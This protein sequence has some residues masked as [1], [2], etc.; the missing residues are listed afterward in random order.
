MTII[1]SAISIRISRFL[2]NFCLRAFSSAA[3]FLDLPD[4]EDDFRAAVFFPVPADVLRLPVPPVLF[5]FFE[6]VVDEDPLFLPEA[7]FPVLCAILFLC[8]LPF[9]S[10][11]F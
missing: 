8:V 7:P 2:C 10:S 6:D 4:L 11:L 9:S 1:I 3:A 5:L